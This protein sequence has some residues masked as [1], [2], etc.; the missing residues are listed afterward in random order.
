MTSAFFPAF[1]SFE[2]L[3][4]RH[5]KILEDAF[6][7]VNPEN[8]EFCFGYLFAWREPLR[9]EISRS[10]DFLIIR[11]TLEGRSFVFPPIPFAAGNVGP[12]ESAAVKAL[13]A[14]ERIICASQ[15]LAEDVRRIA[16]AAADIL[17][18]REYFDYVYRSR[19]LADLSGDKYQSKRNFVNRFKKNHAFEYR[20]LD[21]ATAGI[22]LGLQKKW[23]EMKLYDVPESILDE[24]AAARELLENFGA[25]GLCGCA[26]FVGGEVAAFSV[27]ERLNRDTLVIHLEKA[28]TSFAGSYQTMSRLSAQTAVEMGYTYINKEEDLGLA[29]LRK[30]KLSYHP[31][32]MV[33]K[34][35][36]RVK[37]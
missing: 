36:I 12:Q 29:N 25:L 13:S 1:P 7:R 5:K 15:Y 19:D 8:S 18:R 14:A 28:D 26:I 6:V 16:G 4:I 22:C 20:P 30:A 21:A 10:G 34:Y 32:K 24:D 23:K 27:G 3:S 11:G 2:P 35:E 31:V 17:P 9:L 33:H 37:A